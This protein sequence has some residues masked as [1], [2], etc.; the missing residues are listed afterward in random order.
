MYTDILFD[1]FRLCS[2]QKYKIKPKMID[3]DEF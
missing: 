3:P 2:E 1:I